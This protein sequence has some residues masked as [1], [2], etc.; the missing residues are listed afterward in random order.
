MKLDT[1]GE[2]GLI[3][4]IQVP[5]YAP[6]TVIL[7]RGDD[8]AVLPFDE[9]YYQ[10]LSCDLLVEDIHFIRG[11]ITPQELGYK[12][13]AVNL[14][15]VAAMGGKP[16]HILLSLALPP[17]YT[18]EEWT[19]FYQGVDEICRKYGVN[20]IGGDTTSSPDKLTV[21]VTVLGLVE[22]CHLHLRSHAKPGDVIFTTGTLGGS[23][24]GLELFLEKK[25]L[26]CLSDTQK[27]ELRN[28]H[29]RPEPCC[30]EIAVLNRIAGSDLHALNDISDGLL[31]ECREIA[32]ASNVSLILNPEYVPVN[33][34]CRIAAEQLGA[35][36]LEWALTGGEDY[37]LAGTMEAERAEKICRQYEEKTGKKLTIVGFVEAGSGVYLL[38]DGECYPAERS[39]YNH[40]P[41]EEKQQSGVSPYEETTAAEKLLRQHLAEL[42]AREEQFRVYRHDW[43]NHLACLSGLLE[44]GETDTAKAYVQQMIQM[45]PRAEKKLY[46]TRTVLNILFG[47]KTER[48]EALGMDM[49]ITCEDKLL[50]FMNDFDVI[51]L[52][53]NMLDNGI[54]HSG[55]Q[56]DA[57]LYLDVM[58]ERNGEILIRMENSCEKTPEVQQGVL[59]TQKANPELHGKGILQMQR[60]TSRYGGTFYWQYDA[61]QKKFITQCLFPADL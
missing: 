54:E 12:A 57:W 4:L 19:G 24:A 15:D 35:D 2:F 13:V 25:E 49:Q 46:S 58:Q 10:V 7:G 26:L 23:R 56:K 50:D 47:Q 17:D 44:C 32:E 48:A 30:E 9:Q 1:L 34:T 40:F 5:S 27:E 3:D 8:C 29:C 36:G 51:T 18:V 60:I 22:H 39:G 55:I 6:E 28:C 42:D 45:V 41:A 33:E 53:G 38:K 37:Q 21:N 14:S 52:L 11:L 61:A 20:V 59:T 16:L 31:S 43:N